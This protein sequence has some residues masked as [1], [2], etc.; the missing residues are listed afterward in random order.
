MNCLVE[1]LG[2]VLFGNGII[3]VVVFECREFVK[4]LVK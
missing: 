2:F 4:K 3:L 1:V